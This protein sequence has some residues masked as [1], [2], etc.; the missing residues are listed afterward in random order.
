MAN[1]LADDK[2]QQVLALG[3]LG[4]S[5]RRIEDATGVRRETSSAYLKAAGI[6][7]RKPRQVAPPPKP[8]TTGGVSTDCAPQKPASEGEVSTDPAA[9]KAPSRSPTASAC[10]PYRDEIEQALRLGRNAVAIYQDLVTGYG[11][12]AKY[13][14][15]RVP[16]AFFAFFLATPAPAR[17]ESAPPP[18]RVP[19]VFF[20]AG[21]SARGF[22]LGDKQ[23]HRRVDR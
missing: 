1:V 11:F 9:Q 7:V 14:A 22:L 8:A 20:L 10:E 17:G 5:L 16:E 12:S 23:P 4:W 19:E 18:G 15:G 3:R 13:A 21:E 2:Q 6:A